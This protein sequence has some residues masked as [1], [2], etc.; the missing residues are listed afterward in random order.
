M[1][2]LHLWWLKGG[3]LVLILAVAWWAGLGLW[4][5]VL[6]ILGL[7]LLYHDFIHDVPVYALSVKDPNELWE[8]G[9]GE[10]EIWQAYLQ[11][12]HR[13]N[14]GFGQAICLS[15]YVV[16]PHKERLRLWVF[17]SSVSK[18]TFRQLSAL[19]HGKAGHKESHL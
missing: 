2:T 11:G 1:P 14:F 3:F 10:H 12:I 7:A 5:V 6:G 4:L 8:L 16:E 9:V 19:A 13:V 15:F 17:Y 18:T